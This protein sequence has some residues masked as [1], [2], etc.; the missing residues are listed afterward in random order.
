MAERAE[1][2]TKKFEQANGEFT[3]A[4]EQ[5]SDA[6][7]RSQC[8]AEGWPVAV[9]AHHVAGGTAAISGLA[10]MVAAGQPLPPLTMEQVDQG[11]ADHATQYAN[12]TKQ[13]SLDLLRRNG[14]SAAGMIRGLSDEQLDRT[15]TLFGGPMSAQQIIE[16]VL[17]G[18]LTG[19][20][21]SIRAATVP[22]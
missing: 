19:H 8:Q 3:R 6:S 21:A 2:L 14:E 12:C 7:W 22:V 10:Q 9:A 17:I 5:C 13:E 4:V 20:L 18:H 16:D 15:G 1:A 11:N